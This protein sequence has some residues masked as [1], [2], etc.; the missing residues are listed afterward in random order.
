MSQSTSSRTKRYLIV[1]VVIGLSVAVIAAII[2]KGKIL[3]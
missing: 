2:V 3:Q 1:A